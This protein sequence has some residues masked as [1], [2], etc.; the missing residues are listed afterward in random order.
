MA[1]LKKEFPE[2]PG[3]ATLRLRSDGNTRGAI[4]VRTDPN[5]SHPYMTL[6]GS[7]DDLDAVRLD[8]RAGGLDVTLPDTG[9]SSGGVTV[10]SS[11][12]RNSNVFVSGDSMVVDGDIHVGRGGVHI[13]GGNF[14]AISPGGGSVF[15][16]GVDVTQ[17]VQENAKTSEP[18]TVGVTVPPGT[19]VDM[20]VPGASVRLDGQFNQVMASSRGEAITHAGYMEIGRLTSKNGDLTIGDVGR[21]ISATTHNG[22]IRAGAVV[23]DGRLHT[24]NGSVDVEH[25]DPSGHLELTTHNGGVRY[26]IGSLDALSRIHASSHNGNVQPVESRRTAPVQSQHTPRQAQDTQA[27][28][29]R[30]QTYQHGH[31]PRGG[32]AH[33]RG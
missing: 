17:F 9:G 10:V 4:A 27:R 31:E 24:H 29:A 21:H 13:G 20:N 2:V 25:A 8:P 23:G 30:Q 32:A 19:S 7:Q 28:D 14:G 11:G 15:V 1:E 16:N 22:N 3:A 5:V 12:G 6:R 33:Y 18:L 26:G